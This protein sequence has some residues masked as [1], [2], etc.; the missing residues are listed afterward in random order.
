MTHTLR[1][2]IITSVAILAMGVGSA[3]ASEQPADKHKPAGKPLKI[4]I[5]A[6]QS[7]MQGKARVRTIERLNMTEDG[8]PMYRDMIGEEG[9]PVTVK[10]AYCVYFTESR[11]KP[12][13]YSGPLNPT[14]GGE[15]DPNQSFGPEYTFGI[16]TQKH[17]NEPFLIIKTAWGGKSLVE[18]FRPP[19]AGELPL[20]AEKVEKFRAAGTLEQELAKH[21][22][23]TGYYYRQMMEHVQ[24]VLRDPGRYHPAYNKDAGYEIAGFVWFQGW[25][26]LVN[27]FYKYSGEP[28]EKMYTPYTG[29]MADFIRDVR[30]DL[31]AP[32]MPFVIGVLG[33]DGPKD[34]SDPKHW[35][36]KAQAA[37]AQ[38]PEFKGNVAAVLTETCWDMELERIHQKLQRA[39]WE[40][41]KA[42]RPDIAERAPRAANMLKDKYY[43]ELMPTALTP[44]EL[45]LKH[46]GESNAS[47]HYNGSAYIYGKIGKAFAEAMIEMHD[48]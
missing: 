19:S 21:K 22:E 36:R 15:P 7:N 41:V 27:S 33:V 26:D 38:M 42:E 35:F 18:Q 45:R 25:N 3:R 31:D 28:M 37:P 47:F 12:V 9:N 16:Y 14:F 20:S 11:G 39:A 10:D 46:T 13:V 34:A 2:H 48:N 1:R 8:K 40:K 5:L 4:F 23:K 44:E 29:L 17:L 6:G 30:K 43:Q 24:E 32:A